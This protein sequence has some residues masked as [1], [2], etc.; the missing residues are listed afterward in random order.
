MI[1]EVEQVAVLIFGEAYTFVTDEGRKSVEESARK[2]N[3][4]MQQAAEKMKTP[5]PRRVAVL[6][7]MKLAHDLGAIE[8]RVAARQQGLVD[9]IDRELASLSP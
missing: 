1:S 3:E 4:L 7:A 5:D 8:Q 6:V 9:Y 2:V